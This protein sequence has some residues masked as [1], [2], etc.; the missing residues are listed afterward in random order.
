MSAPLRKNRIQ[1][2]GTYAASSQAEC[3]TFLQLFL[4]EDR[5]VMLNLTGSFCACRSIFTRAEAFLG[6]YGL[7]LDDY[8]INTTR[9]VMQYSNRVNNGGNF[10][11]Q[12]ETNLL[13]FRDN[14]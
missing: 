9:G 5:V 1:H 7:F 2:P 10:L 4:E 14:F 11:H 13:Q 12:R 3:E 6:C 8:I